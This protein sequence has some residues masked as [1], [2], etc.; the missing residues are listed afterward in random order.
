VKPVAYCFCFFTV[1]TLFAQTQPGGNEPTQYPP[2]AF[3]TRG[4][5]YYFS[6]RRHIP[7]IEEKA[8][9]E[10][11]GPTVMLEDV[12]EEKKEEIQEKP[13]PVSL[14]KIVTQEELL[15]ADPFSLS[16]AIGLTTGFTFREGS[17]GRELIS[18]GYGKAS[19]S[20]IAILV[21]GQSVNPAASSYSPVNIATRSYTADSAY[22][23]LDSI[24]IA[25]VYRVEYQ[26]TSGSARFGPGAA[27]GV[28]NIITHNEEKSDAS[29]GRAAIQAFGVN[30]LSSNLIGAVS[31][32]YKGF[33]LGASMNKESPKEGF[34]TDRTIVF[35]EQNL[36]FGESHRI[37]LGGNYYRQTK[38]SKPSYFEDIKT[39]AFN[40]NLA[41]QYTSSRVVAALPARFIYKSDRYDWT[42]QQVN[43]PPDEIY[44]DIALTNLEISPQVKVNFGSFELG[45]GYE[46]RT[47]TLDTILFTDSKRETISGSS[48]FTADY[49]SHAGWLS[50]MIPIPL[51]FSVLTV[52][53]RFDVQ[54]YSLKD[55]DVSVSQQAITYSGD[56]IFQP[57]SWLYAMARYGTVWHNP[58]LDELY[59]VV[60]YNIQPNTALG[61]EAGYSFGGE[62]GF[63]LGW[64][65]F[66]VEY[67]HTT[68]N[69]EIVN[70]SLLG[71]IENSSA[72][73]VRNIYRG[74][75]EV[76]LTPFFLSA[77]YTFTQA[78]FPDTILPAYSL[79]PAHL[80]TGGV[81]VK[82]PIVDFGFYADVLT[83]EPDTLVFLNAV[84]KI[85]V[86]QRLA[87]S[88]AGDNLLDTADT[89]NTISGNFYMSNYRT[90]KLSVIY[91]W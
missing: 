26:L 23:D 82:N 83:L 22:F 14:I 53:G 29:A 85:H 12:W 63:L 44:S 61:S 18:P 66:A 59:G 35:A 41:Y 74:T 56:W 60:S 62:A 50:G 52:E 71:T 75:A 1:I 24:A 57:F 68:T 89:R 78:D 31:Y 34:E 33:S 69:N 86:G 2:D 67:Q 8:P 15:E 49:Q 81:R 38:Q 43:P 40:F 37:S 9:P 7:I 47:D 58:A 91:N 5:R 65:K 32:Q 70:P 64:F 88:L 19:G 42:T 48:P 16:S 13:Q 55:K 11:T 39:D 51:L 3:M 28:I 77:A 30:E 87:F 45:G 25:Q 79:T 54:N 46:F 27:G 80:I 90:I 72:I 20:R 73:I 36:F 4:D 84:I 76:N 6:E 17:G 10:I 21:D